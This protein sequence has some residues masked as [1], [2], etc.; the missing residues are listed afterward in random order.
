MHNDNHK[1][2]YLFLDHDSVLRPGGSLEAP[3][4]G[5][6]LQQLETVLREHPR[7]SLIITSQV[8]GAEGLDFFRGLFS[9]DIAERV[10]GA[11]AAA[12]H[13]A[14]VSGYLQERGEEQALWIGLGSHADSH[15]GADA[16]ILAT[17]AERGFDE[18][19]AIA[20]HDLLA[21][22]EGSAS[23]SF[24]SIAAEDME[25]E[26]IELSSAGEASLDEELLRWLADRV[27]SRLLPALRGALI[28][29]LYEVAE[30]A[31]DWEGKVALLESE[32]ES[33]QTALFERLQTET[34]TN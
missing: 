16:E 17:V 5:E 25:I 12:S 9:P 10:V 14:G 11:T 15:Y 7:W 1:P 6:R 26:E 34:G 32:L 22:L 8:A 20:L 3:I 33:L 4:D 29:R 19:A 21:R 28:R 18:Y 31:E 23:G 27:D 30:D 2:M 13:Q 24:D